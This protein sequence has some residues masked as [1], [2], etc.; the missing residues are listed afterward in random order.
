MTNAIE[1]KYKLKHKIVVV[2][3]IDA[4]NYKYKCVFGMMIYLKYKMQEKILLKVI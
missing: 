1:Y 4:I 3:N 2:Y